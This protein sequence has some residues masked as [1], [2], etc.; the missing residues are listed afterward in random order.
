MIA[1]DK[2]DKIGREGVE[3]EFAERGIEGAAGASLLDFFGELSSLD[4]AAEIAAGEDPTQ[5]RQALN[6]AIIGRLV[7]FVGDNELGARRRG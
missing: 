5:K 7:E 6:A 4:Q 1:L 3:K 2:L